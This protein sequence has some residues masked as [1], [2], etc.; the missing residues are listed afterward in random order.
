MDSRSILDDRPEI[1]M[2]RMYFACMP[3]IQIRDVSIPVHEA[4]VRKAELA[5]QSLQQFLSNQLA[6]LAATPSLEELLDRIEQQD[7]G[8]LST[9]DALQAI[10]GERARR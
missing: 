8:K 1:A 3:N 2:K 9:S 5:G 6:I 7:L 10:S 4:L